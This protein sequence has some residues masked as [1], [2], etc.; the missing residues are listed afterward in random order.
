M[1][2]ATPKLKKENVKLGDP[3]YLYQNPSSI[4]CFMSN[5]MQPIFD[6]HALRDF[7]ISN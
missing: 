4:V 6:F 3:S 7:S 2:D 1:N 5:D